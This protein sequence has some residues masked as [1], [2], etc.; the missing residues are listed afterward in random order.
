MVGVKAGDACVD[1]LNGMGVSSL[2]A[3]ESYEKIIAAAITGRVKVFCLDEPPA[4]YLLYRQH[5]EHDF[6]Q[7]FRLGSGEF[8]RAVH[9]GNKATLDLL[10]IGFSAFSAS[11]L[12]ALNDNWKGT[13][14][15]SPE[16]ARFLRYALLVALLAGGLLALGAIT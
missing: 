16:H 5:A 7:A 3:F 9:K 4:N 14:L 13:A 8:H 11:E 2:L 10:E 6:R 15:P 12:Q 1:Q